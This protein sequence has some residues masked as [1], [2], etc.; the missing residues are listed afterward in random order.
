MDTPHESLVLSQSRGLLVAVAGNL[1]T[2]VGQIDIYDI[3]KDCRAPEFQSTTPLGVL[4]HESGLSPDGLTFYS[5]SPA[6]QTIVAVD[7]SNPVLPRPLW[8][9]HYDSHGLSISGDGNRAYVAGINSGLIILDTTEVQA[10]ALN[11]K[12]TRSPAS[13]GTR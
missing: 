4:G 1:A 6:G 8:M 13:S 7:I 11:P 2:N 12:V 9:G 10:R 3:S 5:A